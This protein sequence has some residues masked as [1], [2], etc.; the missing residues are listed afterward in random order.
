MACKWLT[1]LLSDLDYNTPRCRQNI[2]CV[3]S[4]VIGSDDNKIKIMLNLLSSQKCIIYM[5]VWSLS[6]VNFSIM[7]ASLYFDAIL[8]CISKKGD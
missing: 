7:E 1:V 3:E 5:Y 8:V 4:E 6:N 2:V